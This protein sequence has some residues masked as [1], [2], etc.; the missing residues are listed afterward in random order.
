MRFGARADFIERQKSEPALSRNSS[1]AR[2]GSQ[3]SR[4]RALLVRPGRK[5]LPQSTL[6]VPCRISRRPIW[7]RSRLRQARIPQQSATARRSSSVLLAFDLPDSD[8]HDLTRDPLEARKA[9]LR[10]IAKEIT[11]TGAAVPIE[12][13]VVDALGAGPQAVLAGI[14][15]VAAVITRRPRRL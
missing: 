14:L 15:P 8:G 4:P 2:H 7:R 6:A 13:Y 1:G 5:A 12:S 11:K 10:M 3:S 9:E